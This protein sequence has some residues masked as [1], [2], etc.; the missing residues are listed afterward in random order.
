MPHLISSSA[1]SALHCDR[2]YQKRIRQLTGLVLFKILQYLVRL[3]DTD[4]NNHLLITVADN[5]KNK[6]PFF[7]NVGTIFFRSRRL[8][9][10]FASVAA[11]AC[12]V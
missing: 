12:F 6:F 5:I 3:F 2:P 9:N 8:W 10:F 11:D 7:C 1:E 4:G